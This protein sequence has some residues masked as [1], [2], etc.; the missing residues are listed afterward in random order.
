MDRIFSY[1]SKDIEICDSFFSLY[2]CFGSFMMSV[3]FAV[4]DFSQVLGDSWPSTLVFERKWQA[5]GQECYL[6][7]ADRAGQLR[8]PCPNTE[9]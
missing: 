6:G 5:A 4:R 8:L 7:S 3:D 2:L 1:L 9:P